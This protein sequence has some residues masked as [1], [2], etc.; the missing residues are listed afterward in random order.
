MRGPRATSALWPVDCVA[1]AIMVKLMITTIAIHKSKGPFTKDLIGGSGWSISLMTYELPNLVTLL[2]PDRVSLDGVFDSSGSS[3]TSANFSASMAS[4]SFKT[5]PL[6]DGS[7]STGFNWS[8]FKWSWCSSC[9]R[10]FSK[11]RILASCSLNLRSNNDRNHSC[12]SVSF[13]GRRHH[14]NMGSK[15][16]IFI[17]AEPKMTRDVAQFQQHKRSIGIFKKNLL[18][19]R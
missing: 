12:S 4:I 2:L 6:L 13:S 5:L 11:P 1:A 3:S 14:S 15:G 17:H 9:G 8:S 16:R 10:R 7:W 18:R 19:K